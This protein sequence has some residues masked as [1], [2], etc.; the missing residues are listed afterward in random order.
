MN[1]E[2]QQIANLRGQIHG[3]HIG[4]S[5]ALVAL[6]GGSRETCSAML[7]GIRNAGRLLENDAPPDQPPLVHHAA[8]DVLGK[9]EKMLADIHDLD[10]SEDK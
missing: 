10:L 5:V 2:N 7:D 4:V 6:A 8:C 3:L 1:T 9:F